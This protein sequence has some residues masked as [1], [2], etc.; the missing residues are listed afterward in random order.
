MALPWPR[1]VRK[2]V[3]RYFSKFSII[4]CNFYVIAIGKYRHLS[5][6]DWVDG[7]AGHT[8]HRKEELSPRQTEGQHNERLMQAMMEA[9]LRRWSG[10][11]SIIECCNKLCLWKEMIITGLVDYYSTILRQCNILICIMYNIC[12]NKRKGYRREYYK[13]KTIIMIVLLW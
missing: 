3:G 2:W 13:L 9:P 7:N 12:Y 5:P 10:W 8:G 1:V 4:F 11:L 6:T